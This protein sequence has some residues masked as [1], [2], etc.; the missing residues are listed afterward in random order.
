[1]HAKTRQA[2][3]PELFMSYQAR[4]Q[5]CHG[6]GHDRGRRLEAPGKPEVS[7]KQR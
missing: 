1:M 5:V 2:T 4:A 6:P 3:N 7:G